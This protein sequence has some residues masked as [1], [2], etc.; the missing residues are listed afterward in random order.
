[1]KFCLH[2]EPFYFDKFFSQNNSWH[3]H[4]NFSY[5][6]FRTKLKLLKINLMTMT[7]KLKRLKLLK[8]PKKPKLPK[9]HRSILESKRKNWAKQ[10]E[11]SKLRST[12]SS[13]KTF[14]ICIVNG[15]PRKNCIAETSE[16]RRK[17]RGSSKNAKNP[18][19]F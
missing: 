14:L 15:W 11:W 18:L 16:F 4:T 12:W 5:I 19:M 6:F 13:S 8:N 10:P 3:F 7:R 9:V 17:L 1:M 2:F